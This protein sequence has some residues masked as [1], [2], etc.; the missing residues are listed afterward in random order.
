MTQVNHGVINL[1][2]EQKDQIIISQPQFKRKDMLIW[3]IQSRLEQ[4]N[5]TSMGATKDNILDAAQEY[6]RLK[7]GILYFLTRHYEEKFDNSNMF[8]QYIQNHLT[9]NLE[10]IKET[11]INHINNNH[12]PQQIDLN[13]YAYLLAVQEDWQVY[14]NKIKNVVE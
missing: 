14:L 1:K 4:L 8:F 6:K 7:S 3:Y 13:R 2:K 10:T 12:L 5:E 11:I 9:I